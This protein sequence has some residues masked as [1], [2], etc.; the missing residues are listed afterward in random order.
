MKR[1]ALLISSVALASLGL[2][3]P[4]LAAAPGND[5]YASRTVI[6]A[7]PFAESLD[8]TEATTDADDAE[9]VVECGSPPTDA[10]VWYEFTATTDGGL[11]VDV[12]ASSYSAGVIVA[13]G[14]PGGFVMVT[15]GAPAV[16]FA[17]TA[18]ETYAILVIDFQAD[19]SG[20]GG[21]LELSVGEIPPPPVVDLVVDPIGS[22]ATWTGI[23]TIRGTVTCTNGG[24]LDKSFINIQ[25]SQLVGRLRIT[26]EGGVE[27]ACDGT[28]QPWAAEVYSSNGKFAGGKATVF[29]SA[30]SCSN[31]GCG[32]AFVEAKVTLR[33]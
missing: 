26:G 32:E 8:T 25:L 13:T 20:N 19:G 24:E 16:A 6:G 15:C 18:G 28:T 1:L 17:T 31:S 27:F 22:F 9:A 3:A 10:S 5:T 7:I 29:A 21:T 4:V 2:A 23:A 11:L 33:K 12:S 30:F 14:G